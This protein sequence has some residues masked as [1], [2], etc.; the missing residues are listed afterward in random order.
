MSVPL[1][2][3]AA[4][5][6]RPRAVGI[7]ALAAVVGLAVTSL[8]TATALADPWWREEARTI[9]AAQPAPATLEAFDATGLPAGPARGVPQRVT[10]SP[11][12]SLKHV[13]GG[14]SYVYVISGSVEIIDA[15]GT[16]TMHHAG[17][18]FWEPVGRV[19]TARTTEGAELFT[20]RFLT[21]GAESTIP[22]AQ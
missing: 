5:P 9:A 16:G 8:T 3:A 11:G 12:F 2:A 14:P 7:I 20:L 22:L 19:H 1:L 10:L 4:S 6:N 13:H 15:D 18:F 17:D 21:P